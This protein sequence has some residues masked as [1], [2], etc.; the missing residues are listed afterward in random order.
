M[1][2]KRALVAPLDWGLGHS[3][4]CIPIIE[5]LQRKGVEVVIGGEGRSL[6][7][8]RREFP[9]L[10]A[11]ELPGYGIRYSHK[12][13]I[14]GMMLM[15]LPRIIGA[16]IREHRHLRH[17]IRHHRINAVISDNRFGLWTREVP[18]VY[19]THQIAIRAPGSLM[20]VEPI[21]RRLH[22]EVMMRYD[23]CW[24]PDGIGEINL[25][26]DL[27]HK[28][29]PPPNGYFVGP[30]SRFTQTGDRSDLVTCGTN[31]DDQRYDL[32]AV[33][34]GPEP[35]RTLFERMVIPQVQ[36]L[37]LRA[38][39]VQGI[40]ESDH[41][42][43]LTER[44]TLIASMNGEELQ[45]AIQSSK[46][47]L[48]RSGYSSIMDIAALGK[49]AIIVPTPGQTEQE[50]LGE[51]FHARKIYC[52]Q[53]QHTFDLQGALKQMEQFPGITLPAEQGWALGERIDG[54]VERMG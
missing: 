44:I 28:Y 12:G 33:L 2:R 46:V 16:I 9:D 49:K 48:M 32:I 17:I 34:S 37:G 29:P 10:A 51:Y 42:S 24:I 1:S 15:Q 25:S 50:Y 4:R 7:L 5:R 35:Q 40:P 52:R 39:I 53:H 45:R 3:A 19:I 26:G 23:E 38:L 41:R 27:G 14:A 6:Q 20:G 22:R 54:L 8:L 11:V 36:A 31:S 21:L 30:L 43:S 47:V 13:Y 18:C